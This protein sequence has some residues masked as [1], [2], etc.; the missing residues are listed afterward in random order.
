LLK[1]VPLSSHLGAEIEDIDLRAIA[2]GDEAP[3]AEIKDLIARHKVLRFRGQALE[4]GPLVDLAARFGPVRAL[5]RTNSAETTHIPGHP[6]IKVVSNVQRDGR[7]IGDGGST[8][9][10]WHTDGSYLP[11]MTALTFL[12]GV[13]TPAKAPPK[14]C[15]M[16]LQM[17]YDRLPQSI[18]D[19]IAP[20]QAI[21]YS[22]FSYAPEFAAEIEALPPGADRRHIGPRHPLVYRHPQTGRLSLLPPRQR[23]CLIEGYSPEESEKL[24]HVLWSVIERTEDYWGDVIAPGDLVLFDNRI[25]LHR[26][27]A[28]DA[29]E[30]RVLWHVTTDGEPRAA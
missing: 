28:F 24:A 15:F 14:T 13:K 16:D 29:G 27:D 18:A 12:Y 19:T 9:N 20:L 4:P 1:V 10:A 22:V 6:Q 23:A 17:V 2:T 7:A 30:E 3:V 5:K 8:E 26:R 25:S 21:H 11:A